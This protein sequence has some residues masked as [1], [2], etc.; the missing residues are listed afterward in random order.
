MLPCSI[1][2]EKL[3]IF[4]YSGKET[5]T[6]SAINLNLYEDNYHQFKIQKSNNEIQV[7]WFDAE[8]PIRQWNSICFVRDNANKKFQIF[9]NND[10]VYSYGQCTT[11]GKLYSTKPLKVKNEPCH[12]V[13][14][15]YYEVSY[16]SM[17]SC[18]SYVLTKK[19]SAK[20]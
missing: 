4:F 9:Q 19:K 11:K 17:Y 15:W 1:S 13:S 7:I 12:I 6:N 14:E 2:E 3:I 5:I 20:K 10:M 18:L 8:V 16:Q